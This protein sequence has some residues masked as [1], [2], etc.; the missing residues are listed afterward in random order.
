MGD[1]PT[2]S[3]I[4]PKADPRDPLIDL[5]YY[6]CMEGA[7]QGESS[8]TFF[9]GSPGNTG[10]EINPPQHHA[11]SWFR[12]L[13]KVCAKTDQ[14]ANSAEDSDKESEETSNSLK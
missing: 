5:H 3:R 7:W 2:N 4:M 1:L 6:P 10:P 11:K 12:S 9:G 14:D 13:Q 8:N